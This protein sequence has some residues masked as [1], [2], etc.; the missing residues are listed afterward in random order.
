VGS[1]STSRAFSLRAPIGSEAERAQFQR[2]L[3]LTLTIVFILGFAFWVLS[4][5][6]IAIVAHADLA[7]YFAMPT[8][9][10]QVATTFAALGGA[11]FLQRRARSVQVLDIADVAM[12][13]ALGVGWVAMMFCERG[14]DGY[15]PRAELVPLLASS[16]TL[17]TRAALVPS[18]AARSV[19]V[20]AATLSPL[21]PATYWIHRMTR[22]D[23]GS[24]G[25]VVY[26]TMWALLCITCTA[27]ISQVI[28]GLRL[29]VRKAMQLGQYLLE[30]KLGEGGM[31]VVYRASHK[32]LRR[33]CAIKLL[34]E[35]AGTAT[36]TERFEREVQITARLTH[37]NSQKVRRAVPG[38]TT[39]WMMTFMIVIIIN[40]SV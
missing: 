5:V 23:L 16:Y 9:H 18:T 11:L 30:E 21:I 34:G 28:Y 8:V 26:I 27:T 20:G 39:A 17:A 22:P 10:V 15:G 3:A 2:R 4:V 25:H 19:A 7:F 33:P 6:M 32:M 13:V 31:G 29:E 37:P 12:T 35:G 38:M 36:A 24:V 40:T 14:S 1:S